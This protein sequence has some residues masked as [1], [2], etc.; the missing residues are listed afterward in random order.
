MPAIT[1]ERAM[2][3]WN[4][5]LVQAG[6]RTAFTAGAQAAMK[7]RHDSGAWIGP[8][9]AKVA[10]AALGAALVDGFMGQ[11]HPDSMRQKVMRHGVDLAQEGA[12]KVPEHHGHSSRSRHRH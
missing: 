9:G 4:N 12:I 10:T 5:P 8:K 6:A 3:W 2:S 11:K 7:S 1:K